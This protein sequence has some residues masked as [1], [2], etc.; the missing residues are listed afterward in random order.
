MDPAEACTADNICS[1][2]VTSYQTDW[3]NIYSLHNWVE[4]LDL[5]CVPGWK[6]GMLGS[7]IFIGWC[8]TLPWLPRLSDMY[9]R[10]WFFVGGMLV[11]FAL[12]TVLFFT[13]SIDWM[14]VVTTCFGMMTTVRI[15]IAFVYMM[16]LMPRRLQSNYC[17]AYNTIEGSILLLSTLYFWFVSNQWVYF[18][19]FGYGM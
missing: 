3:D 12:Y 1:G 13:S 10:K 18:S 5:Q 11:D 16:E 14:I 6:L 19:L 17:A 15:N 4:K 8:F 7:T 2:K 9:S